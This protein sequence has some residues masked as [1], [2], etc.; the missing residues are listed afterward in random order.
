MRMAC[1]PYKSPRRLS[2]LYPTFVSNPA[3]PSPPC[4]MATRPSRPIPIPPPRWAQRAPGA[5]SFPGPGVDPLAFPQTQPSFPARSDRSHAYYGSP[6]SDS[7]L[8]SMDSELP[9]AGYSAQRHSPA[10]LYDLPAFARPRTPGHARRCRRCGQAYSSPAAAAHAAQD[11]YSICPRCR[12]RA[13]AHVHQRAD[14]MLA[15]DYIPARHRSSSHPIDAD[16]LQPDYS[17]ASTTARRHCAAACEQA[18]TPT[19]QPWTHT[20]ACVRASAAP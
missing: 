14:T 2:S 1:P 20:R 8:F 5:P 12:D 18:D 17:A 19:Y 3:S 4:L 10:P 16:V 7:L 15:T 11:P 13:A 9:R 6:S